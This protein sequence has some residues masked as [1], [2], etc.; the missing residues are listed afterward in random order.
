MA[1]YR[2]PPAWAEVDTSFSTCRLTFNP[3]FNSGC[4]ESP[5][6]SYVNSANDA[7]SSKLLKRLRMDFHYR[8]GFFRVQQ[9]LRDRWR[10][11][12]QTC[13]ILFRRWRVW[14]VWIGARCRGHRNLQGKNKDR[15][16]RSIRLIDSEVLL[17]Q[18]EL[19]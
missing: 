13:G 16:P 18:R 12:R 19:L 11:R 17:F 3:L 4:A 5:Q 1:L 9:R 8:G 14:F 15:Y 6:L 2:L 7:S 10:R